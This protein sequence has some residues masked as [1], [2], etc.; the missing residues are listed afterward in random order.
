MRNNGRTLSR[1]E[2]YELIWSMPATKLAKE[3]GISDVGLGKICRRMEVPKPALG[4][5]RKV[6]VGGRIPRKPK[7]KE[8]SLKGQ[9]QATIYP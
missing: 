8:L 2:L 7:L 5:W 9:R 4:Y 6:E 1:E 3:I